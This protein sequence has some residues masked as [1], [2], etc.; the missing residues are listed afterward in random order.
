MCYQKI[1][2]FLSLADYPMDEINEYEVN[3]VNNGNEVSCKINNLDVN[4]QSYFR[5]GKGILFQFDDFHQSE[6]LT[7]KRSL[8]RYD[9]FYKEAPSK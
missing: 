7:D 8:L 9:A 6:N 3:T 5:S 1:L 4:V 2:D